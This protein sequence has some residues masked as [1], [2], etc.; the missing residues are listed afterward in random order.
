MS[1]MVAKKKDHLSQDRAMANGQGPPSPISVPVA[2]TR[3]KLFSSSYIQSRR[4]SHR[5]LVYLYL[6]ISMSSTRLFERYHRRKIMTISSE[7]FA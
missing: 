3:N 4:E 5:P 6:C 7:F 1:R 2:S